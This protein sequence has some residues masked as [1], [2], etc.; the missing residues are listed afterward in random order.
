MTTSQKVFEGVIVRSN[1]TKQSCIDKQLYA[2]RFLH[3]VR[4]DGFSD[5]FTRA[6]KKLLYQCLNVTHTQDY[7]IQITPRKSFL[8]SA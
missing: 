2:L 6:S 4:N 1:T 3:F 8:L 5:F 7:F